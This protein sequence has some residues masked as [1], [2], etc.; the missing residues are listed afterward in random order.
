M[1]TSPHQPDGLAAGRLAQVARCGLQGPGHAGRGVAPGAGS[2]PL[3]ERV[4]QTLGVWVRS[5]SDMQ[6]GKVSVQQ[7]PGGAACPRSQDGA[8]LALFP[9]RS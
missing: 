1:S 6:G 5:D 4:F 2:G 8:Y 9:L 3:E 7:R